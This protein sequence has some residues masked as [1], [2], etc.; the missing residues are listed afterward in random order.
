MAPVNMFTFSVLMGQ[1]K[2][3]LD[4]GLQ[5]DLHTYTLFFDF[6]VKNLSP[7]RQT[8]RQDENNTSCT[9]VDKNLGQSASQLN[10]M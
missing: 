4:L 9:R 8:V 10:T 6:A 1:T 5:F 3:I 7:V 2:P